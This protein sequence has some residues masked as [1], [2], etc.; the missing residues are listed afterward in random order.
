MSPKETAIQILGSALVG[1]D[2]DLYRTEQSFRHFSE[3]EMARPYGQ[4]GLSRKDVLERS[5]Q[6]RADKKAALR[7]AESA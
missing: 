2:D 4:S 7:W 6:A 5:R 3:K 1:A